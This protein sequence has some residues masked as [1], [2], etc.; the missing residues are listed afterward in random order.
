ME[1][2]QQLIEEYIL[3][4]NLEDVKLVLQN[5]NKFAKKNHQ[6]QSTVDQIQQKTQ[7]LLVELYESKLYL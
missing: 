6:W 1:L 5:L 2:I 3:G 7:M 4:L